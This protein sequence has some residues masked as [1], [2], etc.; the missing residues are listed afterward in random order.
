MEGKRA[1]VVRSEGQKEEKDVESMGG[2]EWE[3]EEEEEED[4]DDEWDDGN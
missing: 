4:D 3:E 1:S 2:E